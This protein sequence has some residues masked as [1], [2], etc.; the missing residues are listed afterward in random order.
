MYKYIHKLFTR[1]VQGHPP[2]QTSPCCIWESF[3]LAISN[4]GMNT[5]MDEKWRFYNF[6]PFAIQ[7]RV[8][9]IHV[10]KTLDGL[11]NLHKCEKFIGIT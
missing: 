2:H 1:L 9:G 8:P 11:S 4:A 6:F 7:E 10:H 5:K 3:I